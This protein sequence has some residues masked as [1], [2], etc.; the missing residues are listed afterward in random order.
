MRWLARMLNKHLD[1]NLNAIVHNATNAKIKAI[2]VRVKGYE[3]I[4]G[5]QNAILVHLGR[6]RSETDYQQPHQQIVSA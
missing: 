3:S 5:F 1:G 2:K 4:E 6:P